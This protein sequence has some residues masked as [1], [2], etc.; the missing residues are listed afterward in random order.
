MDMESKSGETFRR[1]KGALRDILLKVNDQ[2][3]NGTGDVLQMISTL[4]SI[5]TLSIKLKNLNQYSRTTEGDDVCSGLLI[6]VLP[7][8]L[9]E[10]NTRDFI[11]RF[12][13]NHMERLT[14]RLSDN[15]FIKF[16]YT[17]NSKIMDLMRHIHNR[18]KIPF[19]MQMF[20]RK[21]KRIDKHSLI[22]DILLED[23]MIVDN[24]GGVGGGGG[25]N[26]D[27][28]F[29][30][31]LANINCKRG[32]PLNNDQVKT[33]C[34]DCLKNNITILKT[35]TVKF[36]NGET[37]LVID[38]TDVK[39][40]NYLNRNYISSYIKNNSYTG[41]FH[42]Y[43]GNSAK[44]VF[45]YT[46]YIPIE[47]FLNESKTGL[48]ENSNLI[49]V[50]D[51]NAN[52]K[53]CEF[54]ENH[55][56]N[57]VLKTRLLFLSKEEIIFIQYWTKVQDLKN[58]IK[59]QFGYAPYQQ[60]LFHDSRKLED[61]TIQLLDFASFKDFELV[62]KVFVTEP[63]TIECLVTCH[64]EIQNEPSSKFK[65]NVQDNLYEKDMGQIIEDRIGMSS[66]KIES[67]VA[68]DI[69]F[70]EQDVDK[71]TVN[72]YKTLCFMVFRYEED[73]NSVKYK[74]DLTVKPPHTSIKDVLVNYCGLD[75]KK[76]RMEPL[77][78]KP[79]IN[80]D[81]LVHDFESGTRIYLKE[82]KRKMLCIVS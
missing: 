56:V 61:G 42:L 45:R 70:C 64:F 51:V 23:D 20:W 59:K 19:N 1:P 47:L 13:V 54:L 31:Q 72:V 7:L 38:L 69:M 24:V 66:L 71:I 35:I 6:F 44:K 40:I 36:L 53:D 28:F 32:S 78:N 12:G 73:R 8:A 57:L 9:Y 15:N 49:F 33:V 17:W 48:C 50:P 10:V 27:V 30:V 21:G 80:F 46:R 37:F 67:N 52:S 77:L 2:P 76:Y 63:K 81:S 25:I 22:V 43:Y 58:E 29:T 11:E 39:M 18:Y 41:R 34:L 14:I 62:I 82:T 16:T 79:D 74:F 68:E 3:S 75:L 26:Y 5:P 60:T 55:K 4:L 65:L